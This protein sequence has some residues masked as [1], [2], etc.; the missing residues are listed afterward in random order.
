MAS[1]ATLI[2][3]RVDMPVV[4]PPR[5]ASHDGQPG[6]V[7]VASLGTEQDEDHLRRVR[8]NRLIS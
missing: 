1:D 6:R 2:L 8:D 3:E 5:P 4:P 7:G